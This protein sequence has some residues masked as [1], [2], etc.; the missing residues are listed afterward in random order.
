MCIKKVEVYRLIQFVR[1]QNWKRLPLLLLAY[2][3][4]VFLISGYKLAIHCKGNLYSI[5]KTCFFLHLNATY[6][7]I[8]EAIKVVHDS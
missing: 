2:V 1:L 3:S 5:F 7:I 6:G 4:N 8:E